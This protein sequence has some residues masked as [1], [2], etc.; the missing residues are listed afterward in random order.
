MTDGRTG[1][2]V[3]WVL[4]GS[5]PFKPGKPQ[6]IALTRGLKKRFARPITAYCSCRTVGILRS[7]AARSG[8]TVGYPPNPTT[9]R[10]LMRLSFTA[11]AARPAP[12]VSEARALAR[13]PDAVV[14]AAGKG[15]DA[16]AGKTPP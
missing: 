1:L 8:G 11:A 5:T 2:P 15:W 9:A 10:G 6:A 4:A 12:K 13:A 16:R 7:Q 14:V 3:T